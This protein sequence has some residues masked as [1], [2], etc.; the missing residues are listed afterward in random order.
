MNGQL[1]MVLACLSV[2]TFASLT[3]MLAEYLRAEEKGLIPLSHWQDFFVR[4]AF[5][6]LLITIQMAFA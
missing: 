1:H 2:L 3:P 5:L 4:A 6:V